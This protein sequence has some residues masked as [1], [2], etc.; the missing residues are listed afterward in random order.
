MRIECSYS[1]TLGEK[2]QCR[3]EYSPDSKLK[4]LIGRIEKN[5]YFKY[6]KAVRLVVFN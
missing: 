6:K 4:W 1:G 5:Y 3:E 2:V